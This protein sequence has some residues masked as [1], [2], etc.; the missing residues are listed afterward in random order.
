MNLKLIAIFNLQVILPQVDE[1]AQ[2]LPQLNVSLFVR[3]LKVST[4]G[5]IMKIE[6]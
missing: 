1:P 6:L 4:D 5:E 3:T 2:I